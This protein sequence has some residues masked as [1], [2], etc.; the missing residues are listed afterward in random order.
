MA[1]GKGKINEEQSENWWLTNTFAY[2]NRGAKIWDNQLKREKIEIGIFTNVCWHCSFKGAKTHL[3]SRRE[4][5]ASAR[6]SEIVILNTWSIDSLLLS[7]QKWWEQTSKMSTCWILIRQIVTEYR[8]DLILP[9]NE[10]PRIKCISF[11]VIF[12]IT[13]NWWVNPK[14]NHR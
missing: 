2:Q 6:S 1:F 9:R 11:A 13:F 5:F 3:C 8:F 12:Q 4:T 10:R 7:P 14:E